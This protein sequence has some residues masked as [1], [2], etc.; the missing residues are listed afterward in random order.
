MNC[1]KYR[2]DANA[3]MKH[4]L[5]ITIGLFIAVMLVYYCRNDDDTQQQHALHV[6]STLRQFLA[7]AQIS[8]IEKPITNAATFYTWIGTYPSTTNYSAVKIRT[9]CDVVW[10]N[11]NF[12]VWLTSINGDQKQTSPAL[13]AQYR[14]LTNINYIAIKFNGEPMR[15]GEP[16][17]YGFLS[18]D[19]RN[20][21]PK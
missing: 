4:I 11:T 20:V 16:P 5:L 12:N 19:I 15:Q 17:S 7:D 18:I 9:V 13:I 14:H 6:A 1:I 2:S 3:T 10:V 8:L 21:A